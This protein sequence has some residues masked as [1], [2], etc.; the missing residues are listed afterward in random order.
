MHLQVVLSAGFPPT[1]TVIE[2]GTQGAGQAGTQGAGV[3]GINGG[4]TGG[5]IIHPRDAAVAATTAGFIG[6][7]HIPKVIG[8]F[9]VSM[10]V[11]TRKF[12]AVTVVCEVTF[13]GAGATPNVH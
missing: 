2:P 7:E 11:P 8:S 9:G 5:G 6:L 12:C 3:G 10:I 1:R 4:T 13:I